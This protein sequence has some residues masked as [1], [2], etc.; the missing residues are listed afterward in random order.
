LRLDEP[1][2]SNEWIRF[3]APGDFQ[4]ILRKDFLEIDGLDEEML[5]GYHVDSNLS[6]R[7]LLFRG[8]IENLGETLAGY[9]CNH[10]RERTVY[11]GT[12]RVTNDLER[13]F[14]TIDQ[15]K[16]PAQRAKWGLVDEALEEVAVG[17]RLGERFAA[18]LL[19]A[20]PIS[21]RPRVASD[22]GRVP[23]DLTYDS[24]HVLPFIADSLAVSS[25]DATIGYIG[26]NP[27]LEGM[28][29]TAVAQLGFERPLKVA[30][31]DDMSSVDEVVRSAHVLVVDLG[32][33]S[34]L[35]DTSLSAG[36][37]YEPP[38]LPEGVDL[39]FAGL[40]RLVELERARLELG[41]HPRRIMLVHSSTVF[42][43]SYVLAQ[44]DCS[45]TTA[46]SRVRRATVK[47]IAPNDEATKS[48]LVRER[49]LVRW[50]ARG[51]QGRGRLHVRPGEAVELGDLS[52]YRGFGDGWSYPDEE[53]RIWT[54]GPRSELALALDGIGEDDYMLALSL[55]SVCVGSEPLRVGLLVNGECVDSRAFTR[56]ALTVTWHVELP[57]RLLTDSV[58]DL[59]FMIEHPRS[60]LAVGWSTEDERPLGILIRTI[61][62]LEHDRSVGLEE[63]IS[64]AEGSGSD[65]LLGEG[66]SD[67]E[68]T[69]VW[70]VAERA[71]VIIEP[72]VSRQFDLELILEATA[73]VTPDHPEIELT[74]TALGEKLAIRVF[75]H[76]KPHRRLRALLPA[77]PRGGT[78]RTVLELHL[79]NPARP[80]D[81]GLGDDARRLGL[82]LRSLVVR[83][84]GLRRTVPNAIHDAIATV[85]RRLR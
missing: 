14:F 73:F 15:P 37:G 77:A 21:A 85:R 8:S 71:S 3:D 7:M 67:L 47:P 38:P 13:F 82:H 79:R 4:L 52:D 75:G 84:A 31:L 23:F 46:H 80:V 51:G 33:D 55:A 16:L 9:H 26:A 70:T 28:L 34:S 66:W 54:Q 57:A 12:G 10:N 65:R 60:P 25:S 20:I 44:L 64:F 17:D 24:A 45:H 39:A 41:E 43:D 18:S 5:L 81:L 27:V 1:T 11:H 29:R 49:R 76:G 63:R 2:V 40:E 83:R 69:G 19:D 68:P 6:K 30:K 78:A 36:D 42:W 74:L 61:A 59:T 58:V 72:R 22:A 35:I 50:A 48:A 56:E 53:G 32:V 62:F